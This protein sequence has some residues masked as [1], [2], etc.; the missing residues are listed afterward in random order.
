M[1]FSMFKH[2]IF[3]LFGAPPPNDTW[4]HL[5]MQQD[6]KKIALHHTA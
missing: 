2:T 5:P 6:L 3:F 1:K 4:L